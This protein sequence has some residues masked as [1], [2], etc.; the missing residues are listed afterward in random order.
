MQHLNELKK[1]LTEVLD[2]GNRLNDFNADSALLGNVPEF[3]SFAVVSLIS[4]LEKH[5]NITI[6]ED[7]IS[8]KTFETL[9]S[10]STFIQTKLKADR[11]S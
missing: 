11:I 1:I 5:F 4:A 2:T 7:E 9:G 6:D 8:A 3:D 10:L